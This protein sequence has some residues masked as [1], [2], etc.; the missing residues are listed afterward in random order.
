MKITILSPAS[1]LRGGQRVIAVHADGLRALGHDVT[2]ITRR[3]RPVNWK[4]WARA[5]MKGRF[6][7]HPPQGS[8]YD[9]MQAMLHVVE[10]DGPL[11]DA[12]VPDADVVIATWWETAFEVMALS[13]EK[14]RKFYLVQ[15]HEVH[16]P[17]NR[18]LAA[19][20]YHLPIRKIVISSWLKRVMEEVYGD[21]DVPLVPNSV[22]SSLF[23]ASPRERQAMPTVGLMYAIAPFKGL[24]IALKAITSLQRLHPNLRII[25]FGATSISPELPLPPNSSYIYRPDQDDIAKLYA[26]CDLFL[27]A[28]RLEGFGLPI[29][30]AMAC[31]TPVVATRTGCAPDVIQ[32]GINGYVADIDDVEG[33]VSGMDN[34]LKTSNAEW[35]C[36]SDASRDQVE[37]YHWEDATK[38]LER[39]LLQRCVKRHENG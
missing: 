16:W 33:L 27:A 25:A 1:S 9:H 31:R 24:D 4:T 6:P 22:D 35:R 38:L 8:H 32:N 18:H 20:T 30:E 26:S 34:I 39:A 12:D 13:P 37:S 10:H 2:I 23:N 21:L 29:L 3:H 14:G 11:T 7:K 15:H 17:Q 28:S 36:M 5:I 19:S